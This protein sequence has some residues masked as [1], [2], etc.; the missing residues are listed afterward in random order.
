MYPP[1]LFCVA[2]SLITSHTKVQKNLFIFFLKCRDVFLSDPTKNI[3]DGVPDF[4]KS[5]RK[6]FIDKYDF[7]PRMG[8]PIEEVYF[9]YGV[10]LLH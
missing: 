9:S 7:K 5:F 4:S 2:I 3:A 6:R 1:T 8:R 10:I